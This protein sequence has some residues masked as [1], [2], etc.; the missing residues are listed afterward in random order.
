MATH[1]S[2]LAWRIPGTE[3]PSGLPSMG[4]HRVG[5]DWSNLASKQASKQASPGIN[6]VWKQHFF[7]DIKWIC[8]GIQSYCIGLLWLR[9]RILILNTSSWCCSSACFPFHFPF[10]SFSFKQN[11][12]LLFIC[13]CIYICYI[14]MYTHMRDI[15]IIYTSIFIFFYIYI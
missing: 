14:Y 10:S 12:C 4:S 5:H 8:D 11:Q 15:Y 13:V 1:S 6:L 2:V 9:Y 7:S 3:E